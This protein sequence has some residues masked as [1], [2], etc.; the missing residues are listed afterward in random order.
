[1]H[2]KQLDTGNRLPGLDG[3][4]ALA[5]IAVMISHYF[6]VIGGRLGVNLFFALSGF[7]ITWL[8]I[9][10]F[11]RNDDISLR[12]FAVRRVFRIFPAY[13]VFLIIV[14]SIEYLQGTEHLD[15]FLAPAFFYYLNY[16]V[17]L[18][19]YKIGE[20]QHLWSLAVEE[21]F[22]IIWPIAF[23]LLVRRGMDTAIKVVAAAI[24]VVLIWRSVAWLGLDFEAKYIYR[25]LDTRF[26]SLLV[27][28]M[29]AIALQHERWRELLWRATQS[30]ITLL[31]VLVMLAG[32][33][34]LTSL[35]ENYGYTLGF[36]WDGLLLSAI[37]LLV[38]RHHGHWSLHWLET[39]PLIFIGSISYPAYLYHELCS[40]IAIKGLDFFASILGVTVR[41][42]LMLWMSGGIAIIGTFTA[43]YL[44]YRLVEQPML[45]LKSRFTQPT[46]TRAAPT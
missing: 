46:A 31:F 18:T 8:L 15:M 16:F 44:S 43:A 27:G 2:L 11:K 20:I 9:L 22:Y 19:D 30:P 13:I 23:L 4:R 35:S 38:M 39:R 32:S 7:L 14:L 17:A 10:E 28:C 3:L 37:L 6:E 29:L 42:S 21:Q 33:I 25:A 36:T 40:G 5:V 26:D 45:R 34:W 41:E 1:M 24:V 12:N